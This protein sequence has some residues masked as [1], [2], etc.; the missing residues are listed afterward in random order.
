MLK[1]H[2]DCDKTQI[3]MKYNKRNEEWEAVEMKIWFSWERDSWKIPKPPQPHPKKFCKM[4]HFGLGK[5][6]YS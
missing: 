2:L 6:I 4:P 3:F 1:K 5:K